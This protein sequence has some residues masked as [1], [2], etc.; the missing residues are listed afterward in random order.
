MDNF[1]SRKGEFSSQKNYA[2]QITFFRAFV[3]RERGIS[4]LFI[5]TEP[6]VFETEPG[7]YG[8][9]GRLERR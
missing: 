5:E 6:T 9:G 8:S 1:S 2:V 3:L 4:P 7:S